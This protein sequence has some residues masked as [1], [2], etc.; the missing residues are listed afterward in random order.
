[1]GIRRLASLDGCDALLEILQNLCIL[2]KL[3][4]LISH[5]QRLDRANYSCCAHCS[6]LSP[7][8]SLLHQSK[9]SAL[10]NHASVFSQLNETGVGDRRQY[11]R[12]LGSDVFSI[13][14]DG[15]EVCAIELL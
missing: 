7:V 6:D 9:S 5:G 12:G 14:R 4:H 10:N 8:V 15:N 11:G 2:C 1:M 13:T 3:P